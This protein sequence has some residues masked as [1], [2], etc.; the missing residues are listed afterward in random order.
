MERI[1]LVWVLIEVMVGGLLVIMPRVI[2]QVIDPLL[3]TVE[4]I[5]IGMD[6]FDAGGVDG[7]GKTLGE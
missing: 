4:E 6:M 3:I 1:T 2:V 5:C 7:G